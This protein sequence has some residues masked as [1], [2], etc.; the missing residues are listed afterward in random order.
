M[1]EGF[2]HVKFNE[3][4]YDYDMSEPVES[5]AN[6]QV[7]KKHPEIGSS[8]VNVIEVRDSE[9]VEPEVDHVSEAIYK[10]EDLEEAQDDLIIFAQSKK[11]FKYKDSYPKDL[12]IG[13]KDEPLRTRSAFRNDNCMLCFI[14]LIE[15]TSV[16][17]ALSDD[18]WIVAMKEELN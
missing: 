9:V 5:I 11:Y 6:L 18:G 13:N 12:I 3:K 17:E 16:N 8:E 15:P 4:R 2:I 1:V 14:S 7:S 10:E